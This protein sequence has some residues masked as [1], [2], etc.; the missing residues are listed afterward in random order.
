MPDLHTFLDFG[1][2]ELV[3][4]VQNP[5]QPARR[6]ESSTTRIALVF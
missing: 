2:D 3:V 5:I 4:H 6:R 1:R